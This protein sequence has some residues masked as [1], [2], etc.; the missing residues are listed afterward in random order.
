VKPTSPSREAEIAA[1]LNRHLYYDHAVWED[2]HYLLAELQQARQEIERLNSPVLQSDWQK[3]E[4]ALQQARQERDS[5]RDER[6]RILD[7]YRKALAQSEA[8]LQQAREALIRWGMHDDDCVGGAQ[9]IGSEADAFP[10]T[11]GLDAALKDE[12]R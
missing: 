7:E 10:C 1:R 4:A 5:A 6:S 9:R 12:G 8:A 3:Q 2:I 11:C